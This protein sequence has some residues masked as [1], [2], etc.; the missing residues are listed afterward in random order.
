[1]I[2]ANPRNSLGGFTIAVL[3]AGIGTFSFHPGSNNAINGSTAAFVVTNSPGPIQPPTANK[4]H[5]A[6]Q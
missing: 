4:A 1:M 5:G 3:I 6:W 2:D